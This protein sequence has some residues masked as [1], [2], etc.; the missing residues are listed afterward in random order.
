MRV[1][2]VLKCYRETEST[3]KK[4][5]NTPKCQV[6][7]SKLIKIIREK[8]IENSERSVRKLASESGVRCGAMQKVL[9][10]DLN[11]FPI[12]KIKSS[13]SLGGHKTKRLRRAKFP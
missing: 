13:A 12:R 2:L 5:R 7:N 1:D 10:S 4:V 6:R 9:T 3:L 11:I 8:I